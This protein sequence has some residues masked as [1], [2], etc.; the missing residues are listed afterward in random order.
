[1]K[2]GD[3]SS[4][5]QISRERKY[6]TLNIND[7]FIKNIGNNHYFLCSYFL[8]MGFYAMEVVNTEISQRMGGG[9]E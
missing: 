8:D 5:L 4:T 1:M 2:N 6:K 9:R 7:S 3:G